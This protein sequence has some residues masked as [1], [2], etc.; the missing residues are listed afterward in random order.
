MSVADQPQH[1]PRDDDLLNAARAALSQQ[2]FGKIGIAVSGGGDS[3][4][5]L[6][7]LSRVAHEGGFAVEAATVDHGLRDDAAD[8][9]HLV[10]QNCSQLGIPH[11][12]LR[13]E[14]WDGTGNMMAAARDARYRLVAEWASIRGV[15]A[16]ALGHTADDIAE[17]F[18]IRLSRKAGPDGLAAMKARFD[19]DGMTWIRPFLDQSRV[20]LRAY[21]QRHGVSWVDDPTNED[22]RFDRTQVRKAL[23]TLGAL[24]ISADVLHSVSLSMQSARDAL[25]HYA[26][27]EARRYVRQQ[28][29]DLVLRLGLTGPLPSEIKRRLWRACVPWIS[30]ADYAPRH[31]A[32]FTLI[33]GMAT[34]GSGT[35]GGCLITRKGDD[36]RITREYQAVRA[37]REK[38]TALWD[39]RW[40][41]DGP[42]EDKYEVRAL[43]EA[44]QECPDWRES[45]LPRSSLIATPA[46]WR[47][48][49]LIAA[50]L[51][52]QSNGWTAQIV[53]DFHLHAFAH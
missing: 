25:D 20:D 30:G 43:G 35:V 3:M 8:E 4:S 6:H 5:V 29:G 36:W 27:I 47:G 49:T 45:D 40:A 33:D 32:L 19:R 2:R 34:D 52:G 22:A 42:H 17:N 26:N 10:A 48:D 16:V 39:G 13:W 24:G 28:D 53:A 12:V 37:L 11:T 14:G 23:P 7:V 41:V 1:D 44:I 21:L 9:A 18:L 38:T 15:H 50:P 31:D 51:A 46:I